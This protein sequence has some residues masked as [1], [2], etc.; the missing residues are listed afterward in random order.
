VARDFFEPVRVGLFRVVFYR[1][2]ITRDD[3]YLAFL[4]HFVH[5]I[6]FARLRAMDFYGESPAEAADVLLRFLEALSDKTG[7]PIRVTRGGIVQH[8][9]K[10]TAEDFE[11]EL[12]FDRKST[13]KMKYQVGMLTESFGHGAFL[14]PRTASVLQLQRD[15]EGFFRWHRH[16][17]RL[18][19]NR[20][21]ARA[22]HGAHWFPLVDEYVIEALSDTG[23][24]D[25]TKSENYL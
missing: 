22:I 10:V 9:L 4:F 13:V 7:R 3:F 17:A 20:R 21:S 11:L 19:R 15:D 5:N 1:N 8:W 23:S 18:T 14:F 16:S 12:H 6:P 24:D 2:G 25:S